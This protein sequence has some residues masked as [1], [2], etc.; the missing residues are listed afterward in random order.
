[1]AD[2]SDALPDMKFARAVIVGAGSSS[3]TPML[4][5]ALSNQPCPSC[6]DAM[7]NRS[8]RNHRLNPS[9]LIQLYHP[10]DHTIH[11]I[12][13][14]CGK[15][16]RE[17]ALKVFPS[18]HVRDFSALLITHGHADASY[19]IDDMREFNRP[20]TSLEVFADAATLKCMR[21][22]Y[23]YL[24]P[25]SP[26]GESVCQSTGDNANKKKFVATIKWKPFVSLE[27]SKLLISPRPSAVASAGSAD[28]LG[29]GKSASAAVW[30]LVPIAV[31]HG[32]DY[33]ANAFL[34]P[35]HARCEPPRLLLYVSDIS[36]LEDNF[37]ADL[38]RAKKLLGAPQTASIE[39]LVIDMLSRKPYVSHLHVEASIA[40]AKLINA[41]KTYFVGMSH[42]LE[43]TEMMAEL[44][45]RGLANSMEIGYDGC[46][47]ALGDVGLQRL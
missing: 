16:F 7:S 24:F 20:G 25:E 28:G 13:I 23:P 21:G 8:S 47:V 3:A 38:A 45:D 35:L 14:D 34:L 6:L 32:E 1:M 41:T 39:V 46:V 15:T 33:F 40:A 22:V 9:F 42:R 5:C 36:K 43:Y 31:P 17:S 2:G 11:N 19:G 26:S 30:S 12:L 29:G 4:S 44:Q 18:F 27:R 10:S 37:F